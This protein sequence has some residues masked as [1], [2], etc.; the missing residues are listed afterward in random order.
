MHGQSQDNNIQQASEET[1]RPEAA[2]ENSAGWVT[3][4]SRKS[5]KQRKGKAVSGS[6][7][8]L[9]NNSPTPPS[10]PVCIGV[11]QHPPHSDPLMET[12]CVGIVQGPS[13]TPIAPLIVLSGDGE[14][15][16]SS[17]LATTTGDIVVVGKSVK[18][19]SVDVAD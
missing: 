2:F 6:D 8:V 16:S 14:A 9:A 15:H 7:P 1:A 11:V 18:V 3:M 13:P 4:D 19:P 17:P 12:S 10:P 5:S